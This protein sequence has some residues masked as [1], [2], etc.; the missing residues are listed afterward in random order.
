M[1]SF[2]NNHFEKSVND[3]HLIL[4]AR[5]LIKDFLDEPT[6]S[7][8]KE[9]FIA[10]F[11]PI[12][13]AETVSPEFFTESVIYKVFLEETVDKMTAFLKVLR[14]ENSVTILQDGEDSTTDYGLL[15]IKCS[16]ENAISLL[17][18]MPKLMMDIGLSE[19]AKQNG[20]S[21][22]TVKIENPNPP[23]ESLD[24]RC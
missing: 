24:Y 12:L 7:R 20:V 3:Y 6:I 14:K 2:L 9:K 15:K 23:Y 18:H 17:R 13:T 4:P 8:L 19:Q 10:P 5:I 1:T 16:K 21:W 11:F 22:E